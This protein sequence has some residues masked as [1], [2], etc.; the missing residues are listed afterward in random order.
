MHDG[1]EH[2]CHCHADNEGADRHHALLGYMIAHNKTHA[3][4]L[5]ELAQKLADTNEA[6]SKIISDA[7][8]DFTS[9]NAKLEQAL[10][11]MERA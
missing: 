1:H 8:A 5:R 9:G 2:H 4:E 3:Q 10:A 6:A 7:A 11:L